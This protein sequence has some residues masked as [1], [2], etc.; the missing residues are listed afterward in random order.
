MTTRALIERFPGAEKLARHLVS[1]YPLAARLG[2]HFWMWFALFQ[3]SEGWSEEQIRRFQFERLR[4]LLSRL[5][6]TSSFYAERLRGVPVASLMTLE[7]FRKHVSPLT[8]QEYA[9]RYAD[10]RSRTFHR[11]A[12]AP[13]STSGTTGNALQFYHSAEDRQREWAAISHQWR[14]VG[15][16]PA[17]SRRAEFRGLTSRRALFQEFPD[18]NMIRFSILD[19]HAGNL[20]RMSDAI[21]SSGLRFF[22]GY[23]S[24]IYL[25]AREIQRSGL[26]FPQPDAVLLASE[27]VYDFQLQQIQAA[28]PNSHLFAHYGCAERT[29]LAGWCEHRR[30]YHVLPLY[31]LVEVE[32]TTREI[33]GTNL[34]NEVN[35]FVRYRMTDTASEVES[36]PCPA[37]H[38]PYT[39]VFSAIDGR[40]EDYLFSR[41]R[42]W[43][44]PAIVTYPLKHLH[45]ILEMQF[46]QHDPDNIDL[47]YV[48]RDGASG[49]VAVNELREIETGLRELI[50]NSTRFHVRE[51][52]EIPRGRTGKYK[53]IVSRLD[54][55]F[56]ALNP[57]TR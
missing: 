29:V 37:C 17:R 14:R 33:I 26:R 16:D 2:Q 43:I 30:S 22:H 54:P 36:G 7:E 25:L 24:A 6:E 42:G 57:A 21:A 1:L 49:E 40:Q 27:A 13:C 53:W 47:L 12:C 50:G 28:F 11:R 5:A 51:V 41:E 39:P 9:G 45:C 3:E 20:P 48:R 8:R 56:D 23:P 18:Q 44:P 15:Y 55:R 32:N 46:Q 19:L 31:S 34:Y 38:R 10:I 52:S 4:S 35:G